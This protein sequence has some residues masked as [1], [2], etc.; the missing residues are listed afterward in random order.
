[1]LGIV[2]L[3]LTIGT[4]VY[5]QGP[6]MWGGGYGRGPGMIGPRL[7]RTER[8]W[9]WT[10]LIKFLEPKQKLYLLVEKKMRERVSGKKRE[11]L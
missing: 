4:V 10:Q 11:D 2:A 5:C 8:L 9:V 3:I 6:G 7:G 1:M